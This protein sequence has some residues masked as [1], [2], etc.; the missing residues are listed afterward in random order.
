MHDKKQLDLIELIDSHLDE[1][2]EEDELIV[3]DD[4]NDKDNH[5][6][7]YWIKPNVD[8][9]PYSI[10]MTCGMSRFPMNVPE[11]HDGDSLIEVAMILPMDWDLSDIKS[12]PDSISWP[13]HHLR[14]IGKMPRSQNTWIGFGH[15]IECSQTNRQF[16]SG[17]DFNS[18]IIFPSIQLPDSFVNIKSDNGLI[19][20]Y[21]AIPLFPQELDFVIKNGSGVLIDKFNDFD[22]Q[23]IVDIKRRNTCS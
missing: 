3:F 2:V 10:L 22:I 23:E 12:K 11:S 6:D 14:A 19:K 20:L 16:F 15:T 13:I 21:S 5:I 9:R 8:Y 7:I 17:T 18:T 1:Y 4:V